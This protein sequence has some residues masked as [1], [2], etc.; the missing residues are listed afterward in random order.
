[1]KKK[2]PV[3]KPYKSLPSN[4]VWSFRR[5]LKYAPVS[6]IMMT[7]RVPVNIAL[8]YAGIYLPSLVVAQVTGNRTLTEAMTTVG[9][10]ML[11]MLAG[12]LLNTVFGR[13]SGAHLGVYRYRVTSELNRKSLGCFYQTYESKKMRDLRDRA[14][15]AT[16]MWDGVQPVTDLP[17][18][19]L[20][21]I[22]SVVNYILFGTV[23]SFVSPWLVPI[24]TVAPAV[25]WVCSRAYQKW[26]YA[27]RDKM[28]DTDRKLWYVQTKS[29][30]F[31]AA[32][33]IRI[34][35]MADWF[36]EMYRLL[37][38][39]RAEWD[40]K[41]IFRSFL[42]RIADLV[43]IL[44]R[45]GAAYALLISMTLAGEITV[46]KFVLYFAAISSFASFIG[47]IIGGWSSMHSTS[48]TLCDLREYLE[49]PEWDG[50]GE[51]KIEDYMKS[52][53]EIT[54]DHVSFRYDGAETDTLHD[55]SFTIRPGENI[56][57]VGLNGAGKTTLVKL[58]CGLYMP[59]SGEIRV[60]GTSVGKFLRRDYYKL[61][62]PVFQDVK[63]AFFSLAE[64]V[65]AK[66]ENETDF[67][68]AEECMR[69][70]GLGEKIDSLPNGIRTKL[71]KQVNKD[72][73]ELSG[74]ETQKLM[75]ARALYK[76]APVLVLDEPTAALDPIAESNIYKEYQRMSAGKS[77]LF[78][79]HRLASTRF[80][81]RIL[82]LKNGAVA[83]EGS[84]DELVKAGGE[85]AE[86]FEMQSCWYREGWKG[87]ESNEIQ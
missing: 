7:L 74:G 1:M 76:D 18:Q 51:A 75:L 31:A 25:N 10:L 60:N 61:F 9:L 78:I 49:Y 55:I 2:E 80:C 73:V 54:F 47:G 37:S 35:S 45:D 30:D 57:L 12:N 79:S 63:T 41:T 59:T 43:V 13:L 14:E 3:K 58:L 66:G 15:R 86:L 40:R 33:D 22:E 68:R 72:G 24:L 11:A 32:K 21:F 48:L 5:M 42:S 87:E 4:A 84:H 53:P 8:T 67:A 26:E 85:Y 71:D 36:T 16:Q 83:E 17:R 69:L 50:T 20:G 70:A 52:S 28:T 34:Y 29:S 62:S 64:T 23:I 27:N 65:S 6:F 77:S 46:D 81:D 82:Y 19:T 39:E 44:L 56:A 38:A